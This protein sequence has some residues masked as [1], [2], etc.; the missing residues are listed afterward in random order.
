M[1]RDGQVIVMVGKGLL[2]NRREWLAWQ[3]ALAI[4]RVLVY[5]REIR[6]SD[7]MNVRNVS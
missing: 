3:G 1:G 5:G 6:A 4:Y 7:G 2:Q